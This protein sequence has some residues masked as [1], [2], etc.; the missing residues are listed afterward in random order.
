MFLFRPL[1]DSVGPSAQSIL[2]FCSLF[3]LNSQI[4][5]S[6]HPRQIYDQMVNELK[7]I[8]WS[9]ARE[10]EKI[11][12]LE[13]Q[14]LWL[15]PQVQLGFGSVNLSRFQGPYE[16]YNLSQTIPLNGLRSG[17]AE[18]IKLQE[19]LSA[20]D[21][22]Q[23]E[24]EVGREILLQ[25]FFHQVY[26]EL[27]SHLKERLDRFK[28]IKL[29]LDKKKFAS[30]KD[31]IER[32]QV[33]HKL[34]L[35]KIE[36]A[37]VRTGVLQTTRYFASYCQATC[38]SQLKIDWPN[39]ENLKS[40]FEKVQN[41]E[42]IFNQRLHVHSQMLQQEKEIASTL[43]RPD[44]RLYTMRSYEGQPNQSAQVNQAFGVGFALPLFDR[45]QKQM[46]IAS[47]KAYD[48]ERTQIDLKRQRRTKAL[49]L[50]RQ[51]EKRL[52]VLKQ[53]DSQSQ[54]EGE[55]ILKMATKGFQK[56][57]IPVSQFIAID[58]QVHTGETLMVTSRFD[59]L[60]LSL[61]MMAENQSYL[62]LKETF[63]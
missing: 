13:Q 47:A 38:L 6:T 60:R 16:E 37:D 32:E 1:Q 56:G 43:W 15:N 54:K 34:R 42:E 19:K 11:A 44:L 58:E 40:L 29:F 48:L 3:L 2:F 50:R 10:Q 8:E 62:D 9:R 51:F 36:M 31:Q 55:Q 35:L 59:L 20:Y 5:A 21:Q 53:Y 57:L 4:Y 46:R 61:E 25:L 28:M 14:K 52:E 63:L 24:F 22:K 49:A 18:K 33:K 27:A 7:P 23:L 12:E 41:D 26:K 30:P 45:G 17:L 39:V